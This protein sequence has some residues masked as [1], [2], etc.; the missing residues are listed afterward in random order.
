MRPWMCA[1]CKV[2]KYPAKFYWSAH[3]SASNFFFTSS[4]RSLN[5][6]DFENSAGPV[7]CTGEMLMAPVN[8]ASHSSKK[9]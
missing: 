5:F 6:V 2:E 7:T 1:L 3:S 4:G 8:N 9:T